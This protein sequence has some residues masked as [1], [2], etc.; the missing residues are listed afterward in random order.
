MPDK[1][2][3]YGKFR[4]SVNIPLASLEEKL[5]SIPKDKKILIVDETGNESVA[6]AELFHKNGFSNLTILF[7]RLDAYL[8]EVPENERKMWTSA[9]PYHTINGVSLDQLMKKN[10]AAVI[11]IR[12]ADEFNNASKESFRNM[13]TIKGALNIP[14]ANLDQ[15]YTSLPSN[16]ET[17]VVVY[18][19]G[20][21]NEVFETAKR[22]SPQGSK[23]VTVLLGGLFNFRWR[24]ANLKGSSI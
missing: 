13:G 6:A 10:T 18:A 1:K 8:N 14:F 24:A 20:S 22:L 3:A 23:N 12:T 9:V 21:S 5:V 7:N 17:P 11:D 16:K 2:N 15:Q 4:S 19:S